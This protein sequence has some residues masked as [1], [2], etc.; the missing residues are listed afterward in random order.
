MID[1]YLIQINS[2]ADFN[3]LKDK[4]KS[5]HIDDDTIGELKHFLGEKCD[6][7]RIENPYSDKDYLSTYYIHYSKKYRDFDKKCYRIHIYSHD[8]YYGFITLRPTCHR[9]I[10]RSYIH[11]SLLLDKTSYLMA[12]NYKANILGNINEVLAF[13]WMHQEP[14]VACCAHVA[15]WSILRYFGSKHSNYSDA[16]MAEIVERIQY[17]YDRK[18]PTR[19]LREEQIS[20]LLIQFGFSTLIRSNYVNDEIFTYI[21]SGLPVIGI[22]PIDNDEAHAVCLIGHGPI[23]K[24]VNLDILKEKF[25]V[26]VKQGN[27][28]EVDTDI[29]LSTKFLDSLIV[30]DD[31]YFPYRTV[32]KKV[33][34][35][36]KAN[37]QYDPVYIV[38]DI[39]SFIIPLYEKMQITYN[40]VYNIVMNFLVSNRLSNLPSPKILRFFITSSNSFKK[41]LNERGINSELRRILLKV[42]MPKFIWCA[43]ISSHENYLQGLVDGCIVIDATD[44]SEEDSPFIVIHDKKQVAYYNDKR[45]LK[46]DFDIPP[47]RLY[48]H[49][50]KEFSDE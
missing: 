21:E 10:G 44:S 17:N 4:I 47:Y 1:S 33:M 40:E 13:P 37:K 28:K 19:G 9:K 5:S 43:E 29:V 45:Y 14:D 32:Y 38:D 16:T 49:N 27:C 8:C 7:I 34:M 20:T 11:P 36:E 30:N 39:K 35:L 41:S 48:I 46:N 23:E 24:S 12:T 22:I 2:P 18:T 50:L 31:N 25:S 3:K 26:K 15:L 42:N 6:M